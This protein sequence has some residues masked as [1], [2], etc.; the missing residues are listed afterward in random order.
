MISSFDASSEGSPTLL[1]H[2]LQVTPSG[3]AKL[4]V[5]GQRVDLSACPP[6]EKCGVKISS[7]NYQNYPRFLEFLDGTGICHG[8]PEKTYKDLVAA[9]KRCLVRRDG[10]RA[11][12]TDFYPVRYKKELY[13]STVRSTRCHLLTLTPGKRCRECKNARVQL[14][15]YSRRRSKSSGALSKY[16]KNACLSTPQQRSKMQKLAKKNRQQEQSINRLRKSLDTLIRS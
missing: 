6:L 8:N 5:A 2:S 1:S 13:E 3:L 11:V 16:F 9:K 4:Y 15:V 12:R 14:R 7:I 10:V